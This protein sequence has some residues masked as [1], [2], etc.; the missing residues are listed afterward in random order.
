MWLDG[1]DVQ[2]LVLEHAYKHGLTEDQ[3][4]QAWHNA[5]DHYERVSDD[6][7][8]DYVAVGFA[9]DGVPVEMIGARVAVGILIYHANTPPTKKVLREIGYAR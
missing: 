8:C 2:V 9:N 3:I 7:A 4:L 6:G 5:S 1:E